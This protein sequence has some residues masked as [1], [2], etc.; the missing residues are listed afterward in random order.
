MYIDISHLRS[1]YLVGYI[2]G[3]TIEPIVPCFNQ[4]LCNMYLNSMISWILQYH[5]LLALI[6][7]RVHTFHTKCAPYKDLYDFIS[8]SCNNF[9]N[10]LKYLK[11]SSDNG[12]YDELHCWI[13]NIP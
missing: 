12:S 5:V 9:L 1:S 11:N 7:V 13:Q 2:K 6:I 3:P 4:K 8:L 10:W